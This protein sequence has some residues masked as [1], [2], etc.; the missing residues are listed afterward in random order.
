MGLD[1]GE[2]LQ[3]FQASHRS[4]GS[5]LDAADVV[6]IQLTAE[7]TKGREKHLV[8]KAQLSATLFQWAPLNYNSRVSQ[9]LSAELYWLCIM[10]DTAS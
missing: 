3:H 1:A 7:H 2:H 8:S 9:E 10:T 5:V 4:E 6:F